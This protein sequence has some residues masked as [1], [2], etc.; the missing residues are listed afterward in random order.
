M[1]LGWWAEGT[2]EGEGGYKGLGEDDEISTVAGCFMHERNGFLRCFCR[3]KK[4]GCS[5]TSCDSDRARHHVDR[6]ILLGCDCSRAEKQSFP[7]DPFL[8][9]G[10]PDSSILLMY[11]TEL[12]SY[13]CFDDA[14]R[15]G[16]PLYN[17]YK[18][19]AGVIDSSAV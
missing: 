8:L 15:F 16:D 4:Y 14:F 6:D 7:V 1:V 18:R 13:D 3:R 19:S 2:P 17:G 10:K 12:I 5:M 9:L 11:W